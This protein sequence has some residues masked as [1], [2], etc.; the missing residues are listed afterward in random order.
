MYLSPTNFLSENKDTFTDDY[1]K[2][3]WQGLRLPMFCTK[4]NPRLK[5]FSVSARVSENV[6]PKNKILHK[7]R[8][9]QEIQ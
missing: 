9:N 1:F 7:I 4:T 3:T 6:S 2:T 5:L 8:F